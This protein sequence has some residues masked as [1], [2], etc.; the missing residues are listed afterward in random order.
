MTLTI[1]LSEVDAHIAKLP[2]KLRRSVDTV[3]LRLHGIHDKER[4]HQPHFSDV[5]HKRLDG[6]HIWLLS[7][8]NGE[9]SLRALPPTPPL[10]PASLAIPY[11][12]ALRQIEMESCCLVPVSYFPKRLSF[13]TKAPMVNIIA[14][15][16][17]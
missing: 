17:E 9:H 15:L 14:I 10:K 4:T 13:I 3:V 7:W 5:L 8:R 2:G 6:R 1:H 12:E 11:V 16:Y